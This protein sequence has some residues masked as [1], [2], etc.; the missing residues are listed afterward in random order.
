MNEDE[1][2]Q[3]LDELPRGPGVY[4][5]KG[6][7]GD[8]VYIGK[9]RNL[10][11]RVRSYYAASSSDVRFIAAQIRKLVADIVVM[12]TTSEKEAVLLEA[13]LIKQHKP[14]YNVKLRDDKDFLC[15]RLDLATKWPRLEVVR[16]PKDDGALY[17]GPYHSASAARETLSLVQRQ[18]L[19]RSCSD[20][21]LASRSRPCLQYQIH[22]CQ[23]PCVLAVDEDEYRANVG[24]TR[25]FL[26]GH[27][28]DLERDLEQR[29]AKASAA[30]EYERAAAYRDKLTAVRKTLMPQQ[31]TQAVEGAGADRDV[32]GLAR[33][34][35]DVQIAVLQ[36]RGGR[37][38]GSL[39]YSLHEQAFPDD[40]VLSSFI[41]QAYLSGQELPKFVLLSRPVEDAAALSEVLSEAAGH[42]VKVAS[43]KRGKLAELTAMADSNAEAC[44]KARLAATDRTLKKLLAVQRRLALA[45]PPTVVECVDISHFGG[46]DTVG[47]IACVVDG[48]VE[49]SRG[50]TYRVKRPTE[51]DDYAAMREVLERRFAR[52]KAF[53]SGWG[54]PDLLVVDGGPGQLQVA[55]A[56]LAD[57]DL[58]H[59]PVVG[60]AKERTQGVEQRSDRVFLPDRKNPIP[61]RGPSDP[62]AL[63]CL[64]RDEA[65]RLANHYRKKLARQRTQTSAL[66]A[67]PG[68]GP[69]L[70][71]AL[72]RKF[73]SVRAV[74]EATIEQLLEVRGVGRAVAQ[75]ILEQGAEASLVK[76][77]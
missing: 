66:D 68:V 26:E 19:L 5:M 21:H 33:A 75:R 14:R 18:F 45:A 65:H 7:G 48:R 17:F 9:A 64:A 73:G 44:L 22:R 77:S 38:R 4:L 46:A 58:G 43:P 1:L 25:L 24:F 54:S 42:L 47:A 62:L 2:K 16:R 57:L 51:G 27:T 41:A 6:P 29:M 13:S 72:L 34:G 20:S 74:R 39:E 10:Y 12:V 11:S 71:R 63:L 3:L 30:L 23:A 8:I 49:R 60:L 37:L 69:T 31:V 76:P 55:R 15:L 56:V 50:R 70:R 36:F 32:V 61:V 40:E 53:E 59:Q 67:I 35:D 28:D 52:A